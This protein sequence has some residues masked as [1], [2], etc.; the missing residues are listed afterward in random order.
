MGPASPMESNHG[1]AAPM[2]P[3]FLVVRVFELAP[4]SPS[5]L[6]LQIATTADT[7]CQLQLLI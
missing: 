4:P 6:F 2:F 7:M 1:Q 3:S 5:C